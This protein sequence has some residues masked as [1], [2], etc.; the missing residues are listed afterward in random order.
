MS[1]P[2]SK[3]KKKVGKPLMFSQ[4]KNTQI[5]HQVQKKNTD[6]ATR[7]FTHTHPLTHSQFFVIRTEQKQQIHTANK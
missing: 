2:L 5:F 7:T 4:N 3:K 1:Q 6:A